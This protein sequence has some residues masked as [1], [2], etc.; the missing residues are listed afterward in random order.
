MALHF[1]NKR[2][3]DLFWICDELLSLALLRLKRTFMPIESGVMRGVF[4]KLLI[5]NIAPTPNLAIPA[6]S[7]AL[8]VSCVNLA[9]VFEAPDLSGLVNMG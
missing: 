6:D 5:L 1:F 9:N 3:F 2:E 8:V 4:N 7:V